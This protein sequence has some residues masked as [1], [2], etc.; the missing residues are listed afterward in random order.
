MSA[1]GTVAVN[2]IWK[3]FRS[4]RGRRLARDQLARALRR[5]PRDAWRWVLKDI[6]FSVGPG[7]SVAVV[8]VNGSGK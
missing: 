1:E 2:H 6:D 8:G 7:E 3:R 4:D 5:P